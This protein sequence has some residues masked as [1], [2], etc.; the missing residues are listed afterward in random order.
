MNMNE[1]DRTSWQAALVQPMRK[2][3]RGRQASVSCSIVLIVV[4]TLLV[5]IVPPLSSAAPNTLA[6][7]NPD[8]VWVD[9]GTEVN[10]PGYSLVAVGPNYSDPLRWVCSAYIETFTVPL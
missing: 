3:H 10:Y 8:Y 4:L 9:N 5:G 6:P 2:D 1:Q 7:N